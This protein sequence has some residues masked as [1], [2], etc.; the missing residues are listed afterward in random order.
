VRRFPFDVAH[1]LIFRFDRIYRQY[2][3]KDWPRLARG[4]SIAS[5]IAA[6]GIESRRA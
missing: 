1:L 3:R 4:F 2:N 6:L 5:A